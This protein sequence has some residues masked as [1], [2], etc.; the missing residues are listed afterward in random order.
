MYIYVMGRGHSGSTILD[1]LMGGGA[2]AESVGELC[3]LGTRGLPGSPSEVVD[4][5]GKKAAASAAAGR[6]SRPARS[7]ARC[8]SASRRR[9]WRGSR[10][11]APSS[12]TPTSATSGAR[13]WRAATPRRPRGGWPSSP[14]VP[15]L[16]AAITGAAGK[17]HLLNSNKEPTRALFLL[18]YLPGRQGHPPRA[19]PARI[20]QSHYWRIRGAHGFR[21]LRRHYEV[22]RWA[23]PFVLLL[24]A[25]SWVVG[26]LCAE[27]AVRAAPERVLRLRYEDLRDDP[28]GAIRA[29]GAAFGLRSTTSW[30]GSSAA[31][32]SRSGTMS[33]ATTSAASARCGSTRARRASARP[34]RAGPTSPRR[35]SA[36]R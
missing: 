9:A 21:F 28:A 27:L 2:A 18:K 1:I 25:G 20:V 33:A 4:D 6:R 15:A 29:I 16:E 10:P 13:W 22:G 11:S 5:P 32:R 24:A 8:A 26:N 31:S 34:C 12:T 35:S 30:A 17:P 3:I 19:R 36:G 23:A 14:I 7:G